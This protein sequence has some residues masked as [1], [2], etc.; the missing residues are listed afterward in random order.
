M[1]WEIAQLFLPDNTIRQAMIHFNEVFLGKPSME[2]RQ[3]CV[4]VVEFILPF[5]LGRVYAEYILPSGDK[6]SHTWPL[7]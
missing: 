7:A 1:T 3:E 2:E 5:A 6:V 4:S